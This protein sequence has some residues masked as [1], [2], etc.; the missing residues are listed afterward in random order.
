MMCV[1][2][3]DNNNDNDGTSDLICTVIFYTGISDEFNVPM[4]EIKDGGKVKKPINFP[5]NY[6]NETDRQK[7]Q[8]VGWYTDTS[9]EDKYLWKFETDV[10]HS[11]MTLYARWE[12]VEK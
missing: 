11:N 9:W 5:N 6:L 2:C 12:P 10:V 7:Y 4:Q 1:G 3:G 8:F